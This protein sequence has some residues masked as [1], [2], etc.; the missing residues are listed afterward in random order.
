MQPAHSMFKSLTH[1]LLLACNSNLG[2][3][4]FHG[5]FNR[6]NTTVRLSTICLWKKLKNKWKKTAWKLILFFKILYH[7]MMSH[8]LIPLILCN[9]FC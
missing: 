3:D 8:L 7:L 4:H 2:D 5:I 6:Q 1:R 9:S